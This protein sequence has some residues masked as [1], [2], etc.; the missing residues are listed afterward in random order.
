LQKEGS[1]SVSPHFIGFIVISAFFHAFYNFMMKKTGG[2]KGFL[3]TMFV[4]AAVIATCLSAL[5]GGFSHFSWGRIHYIFGASFFYILYQISVSKAYETGN[6]S[7]LY[8]LTVLSPIFIPIWAFLFLSESISLLT[9]IGIM[10]TVIGAISINL[11]SASLEEFKK[12][13]QFHKDYRGARFALGASFIYS[14]G[15][16]FD[17]SGIASFSLMSYLSII[18]CFMSIFLVFYW[19]FFEKQPIISALMMNWKPGVIGG[20]T[21]YLSF[22]FFRVALKEI[23]V[24]IAIPIRQV[25]I[26]FAIALGILFLKEECKMSNILGSLVVILGI[27]LVNMGIG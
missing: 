5:M 19:Y 8:P 15:A 1:K 20:I 17:K 25:A 11:R 27:I 24:S 14:F 21:L 13:F 9:G 18:L 23:Y 3:L 16:I 22:L 26:V 12:I 7:A 2:D 6:I 4:M 10:V